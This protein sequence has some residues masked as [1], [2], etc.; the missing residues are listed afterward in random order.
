MPP[1]GSRAT[2]IM[3]GMAGSSQGPKGAVNPLGL[4]GPRRLIWPVKESLVAYL[5][6]LPDAVLSGPHFEG[7]FPLEASCEEAGTIRSRGT[8]RLTAHEGQLDIVLRDLE[9]IHDGTTGTLSA[10]T[11][12]GASERCDIARLGPASRRGDLDVVDDVALTH[13]GAALFEGHY[14]A[15]TRMAPLTIERLPTSPG[16]PSEG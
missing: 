5:A 4:P 14:G 9:V 2:A 11:G 10:L 3:D 7:G 8:I 15:Y 6:A 1:E 16:E 12:L 13:E